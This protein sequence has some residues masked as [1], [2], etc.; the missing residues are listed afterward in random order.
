MTT[1][2]L[3]QRKSEVAYERFREHIMRKTCVVEI[4]HLWQCDFISDCICIHITK[5]GQRLLHS[6][7]SVPFSIINYNHSL[8]AG[9][10]L[11]SSACF[12]IKGHLRL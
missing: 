1:E 12:Q 9:A 10:D 5:A 2:G 4:Y 8:A 11:G 7:S 3:V 6:D